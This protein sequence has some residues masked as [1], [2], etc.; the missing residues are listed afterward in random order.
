MGRDRPEQAIRLF[1]PAEL[2]RHPGRGNLPHRCRVEGAWFQKIASFWGL[3]QK[4]GRADLARPGLCCEVEQ[5]SRDC[6][7]QDTKMNRQVLAAIRL[8]RQ[9]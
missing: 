8:W 7:I 2:H 4:P 9:Y 1:H 3:F 5:A 6:I